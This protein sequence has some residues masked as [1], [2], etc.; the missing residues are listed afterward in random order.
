VVKRS[1]GGHRF[2]NLEL[3]IFGGILLNW[4]PDEAL[5]WKVENHQLG[6]AE[7]VLWKAGT[8]KVVAPV[9]IG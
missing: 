7:S 4:R 1:H 8:S 2:F 3:E 9:Y 5:R 6:R